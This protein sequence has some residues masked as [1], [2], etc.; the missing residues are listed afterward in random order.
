MRNK[1]VSRNC[2]VYIFTALK[3]YYYHY[4][5]H[6]RMLQTTWIC[7][8]LFLH[9]FYFWFGLVKSSK[10]IV[11]VI[12]W[13]FTSSLSEESDANNRFALFCASA[14]SQPRRWP[15]KT[16]C[17]G[18]RGEKGQKSIKNYFPCWD[19]N[20]ESKSNDA[21]SV[22]FLLSIQAY[23]S[24][25]KLLREPYPYSHNTVFLLLQGIYW[26]MSSEMQG[27]LLR[28]N[29]SGPQVL[30]GFAFYWLPLPSVVL[31]IIVAVIFSQDWKA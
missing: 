13:V 12:S 18:C 17:R 26:I 22:S 11:L 19:L 31:K 16:V 27:T 20:P 8:W 4:I 7:S 10:V 21:G 23:E 14:A 24:S 30:I 5:I 9:S 29:K 3:K 28:A 6:Q 15:L 25:E 1:M 2:R